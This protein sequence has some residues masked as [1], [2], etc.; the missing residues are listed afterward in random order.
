VGASSDPTPP[1]QANKAEALAAEP[2]EGRGPTKGNDLS[3]RHVPDSEPGQRGRGLQAVRE[4]GIAADR[5]GP[6]ARAV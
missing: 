1:K 2:G 5:H 3:V 4:A 6:E